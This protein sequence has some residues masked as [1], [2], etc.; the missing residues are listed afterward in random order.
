VRQVSERLRVNRRVTDSSDPS[1]PLAFLCPQ[2]Y[3]FVET[4]QEAREEYARD[5]V[6]V[7]AQASDFARGVMRG[8]FKAGRW[9][10]CIAPADQ[11]RIDALAAEFEVAMRRAAQEARI[12]SAQPTKR[13][14]CDRWH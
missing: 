5:L 7:A 3:P 10:L 12:V 13:L 11:A 8:Y 9:G 6:R 2:N 1:H 4:A 14:A